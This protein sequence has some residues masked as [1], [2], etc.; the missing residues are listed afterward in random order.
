MTGPQLFGERYQLGETLGFGG[1]SEVHRG[2]D[3][4][5]VGRPGWRTLK[6]SRC[7]CKSKAVR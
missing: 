7:G 4:R 5:S 1:M 6:G 2:R 3:L